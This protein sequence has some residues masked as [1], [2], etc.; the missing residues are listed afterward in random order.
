MLR[1]SMMLEPSYALAAG[2]FE[3]GGTRD[4]SDFEMPELMGLDS[5][6]EGGDEE[7]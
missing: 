5:E 2:V 6:V 4:D 3:T 7:E 1:M